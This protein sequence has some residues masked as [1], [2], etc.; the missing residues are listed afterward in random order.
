MKDTCFSKTPGKSF[1]YSAISIAVLQASLMSSSFASDENKFRVSGD[2]RTGWLEYNYGNPEGIPTINKGHKD[3]EGFY[4][5]PKLSLNTPE[6]NGFS[7]KITVAGATDLG[8]ND[9]DKAS[10]LFVFDPT[11][12]KDFAILQE[13]SQSERILS[14]K[15]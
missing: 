2:I 5:T 1:I 11:E 14:V 7:G 12:N 3:S 15:Q 13:F 9:P 4:I 6:Y 10:R 8:I